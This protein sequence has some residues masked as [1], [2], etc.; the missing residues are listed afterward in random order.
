MKGFYGKILVIDLSTKTFEIQVLSEEIYKENLGGKGLGTYLLL[1]KVRPGIN[2][3]GPDNKLIFTTGFTTGTRFFGSSRY[4]VFTKSPQTG[5]YS[6]SYSGGRV[7][8]A[9]HATGYDAVVLEGVA[10]KPLF[11]EVSDKGVIFHS[12]KGVW[13]L[14]TYAAED[15]VL[16]LVGNSS[17]QAVVIGPAG[18]NLVSFACLENNYWRSAG[19]TGAGA[20]MGSKKVKALVFHGNSKIEIAD[21]E[22]LNSLNKE[23]WEKA[24]DSLPVKAY[25]RF[26]TTQMVAVMNGAKA[27]P[28]RYWNEGVYEDWEQISGDALHSGFEVKESAC[29]KCFLACG[30][31]VKVTKGMHKDL[32]IEGPEYETIYAFGGLCAIDKLDEIIYLNDLCDRLG[33]DTITAGNLVAL[34]MEAGSRGMLQTDLEYGDVD[35]VVSLLEDISSKRELGAILAKGIVEA[36]RELGLEEIAIHVKGLEPP[37]YDPRVLKGMGLAYA[38]STRGACHLRAT[39][40][41]PELSGVIDPKTVEGKAKLF[42]EFEDRLTIFNTGT[43]CV[44]F[45]D[46]LQWP[47]LEKLLKA[48]TGWDYNEEKLRQIANNVITNSR[49]FNAREGATIQE[50]RLPERFYKEKVNEEIDQITKEELEDMVKDYYALRGWEHTGFPKEKEF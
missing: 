43:I 25:R 10:E 8:P 32:V 5:L 33:I 41:K 24:K 30:N 9:L 13:G 50:D 29:P 49:V 44:F 48:I 15:K 22:A 7:A 20:V 2:P 3:L 28:T 12:A 39:F 45:R 16:Q 26:G 11:L 37:G 23:V 4:G 46:F 19:R 18:E 17:A 27:F 38:T 35:G 42:V 14:D 47:I 40:Y 36:S 31:I 1:N 21:E 34:V 6:E